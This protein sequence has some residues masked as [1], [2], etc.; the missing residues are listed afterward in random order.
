[1]K[2]YGAEFIGTFALVFAGTGAIVI[3]RCVCPI[4]ATNFCSSV[5]ELRAR[6]GAT[7]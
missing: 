7:L 2:K 4:S 1:M 5:G 3:N 6:T